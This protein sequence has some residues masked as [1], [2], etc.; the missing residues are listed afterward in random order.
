MPLSTQRLLSSKELEDIL[1]ISLSKFTVPQ[2]RAGV[3]DTI[4]GTT[5]VELR[6]ISVIS[7]ISTSEGTDGSTIIGSISIADSTIDVRINDS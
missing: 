1:K 2:G 7:C 4:I 3:V 6:P 5:D